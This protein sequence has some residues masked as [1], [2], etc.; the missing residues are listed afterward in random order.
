MRSPADIPRP[1]RSSAPTRRSS[2]ATVLRWAGL[3]VLAGFVALLGFGLVNTTAD[4]TIDSGLAR[5]R[6]VRP[7]GFELEVL[8]AATS[9]VGS[10]EWRRAVAD[11]RLSLAEL[12]GTPVVLN[13]WASWCPPCRSEAPRLERV[14][15]RTRDRGVLVLGL[16]MQDV[17]DDARGFIDEF[18][19][20]Y[21]N[22]RDPDDVVA[23]DWGATGLPETFFI[24]ARGRVVGHVI[25]AVSLDQLGRGIQA[26]RSGRVVGTQSGGER[27]ETP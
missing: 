13:F 6:P 24:D 11:G 21:P 22:V 15:Q 25:G 5:S 1:P 19:I 23:R 12:R 9:A 17:T 16:N 4:D 14:W 7:P 10:P 20:S 2:T 26:A 18:R 3:I 27:R 8:Q